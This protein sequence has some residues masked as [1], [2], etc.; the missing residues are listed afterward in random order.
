MRG[1]ESTAS[2]SKSTDPPDGR[3]TM[4]LDGWP[5]LTE[6]RADVARTEGKQLD[7]RDR[8]RPAPLTF[9]T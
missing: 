7:T 5:K 6:L 8:N 4:S 9:G 1:E 2:E 3:D